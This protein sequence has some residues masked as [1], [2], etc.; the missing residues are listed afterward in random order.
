MMMNIIDIRQQ[1][2]ADIDLADARLLKMLHA[3]VKEY[4]GG[5]V[6]P[7]PKLRP[8]YLPEDAD[9][10]EKRHTL[11]MEE[12]AKYLKGDRRVYSWDEVKNMAISKNR[13]NEA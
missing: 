2:H 6:E 4:Q 7:A 3:L 11:I 9:I 10:M 13:P 12:H 8:Q 5:D 1:L